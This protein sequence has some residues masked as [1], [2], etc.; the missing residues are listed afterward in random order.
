VV[1]EPVQQQDRDGLIAFGNIVW[2]DSAV[3][4][5]NSRSR[6]NWGYSGCVNTTSRDRPDSGLHCRRIGF[7]MAAIRTAAPNE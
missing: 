7:P 4:F 1:Q 3:S 6:L 5:I 2:I